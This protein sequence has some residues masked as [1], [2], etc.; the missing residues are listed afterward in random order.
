MKNDYLS[1]KVSVNMNTSILS[2]ID[3]LVDNGYFS[4][5]SDFINQAVREAINNHQETLNRI[6]STNMEASKRNFDEWFIGVYNLDNGI[7]EEAKKS[8]QKMTL[9]GYGVL[10]INKNID[11]ELLYKVVDNMTIRGSVIGSPDIKEYYEI[12]K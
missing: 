9:S 6:I 2:N 12:K 7:L 8:G 1:E 11:K 10:I 4:N 5:R 3:L